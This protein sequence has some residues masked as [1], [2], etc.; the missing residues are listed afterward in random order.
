VS[1][2]KQLGRFRGTRPEWNAQG[3]VIW[4]ILGVVVV[5]ILL[6]KGLLR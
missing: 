1:F 6:I 4:M 5:L 2:A 3:I